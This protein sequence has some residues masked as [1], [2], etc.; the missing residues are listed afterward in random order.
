MSD[1]EKPKDATRG[2][3]SRGAQSSS[4]SVDSLKSNET[5]RGESSRGDQPATPSAKEA[6]SALVQQVFGLFKSYLNTQLEEKG[7]QI[8]LVKERNW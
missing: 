6:N 5:T 7:K 8:E 3:S 1:W 2:E 4:A